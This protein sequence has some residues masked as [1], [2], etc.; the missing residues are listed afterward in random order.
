MG[1]RYFKSSAAP[2]TATCPKKYRRYRY[3]LLVF[4][5]SALPLLYHESSGAIRSRYFEQRVNFFSQLLMNNWVYDGIIKKI[6]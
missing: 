2:A 3:P 6:N 4:K 5:S 1:T